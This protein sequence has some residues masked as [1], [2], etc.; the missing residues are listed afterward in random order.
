MNILDLINKFSTQEKCIKHLEKARWGDKVKCVY[1][2]SDNTNSLPKELRHHCNG[3]RK[4]FSVTVGTIFHRTHIELQKWFLV[5][6]L[7][8]NARKGLSAYQIAR[9][10]GMRRP[11]VWSMMHRIRKAMA[12][13]Q[14]ELLSGIVEMDETYI[15]GKPRPKNNKDDDDYTP[16]KRGRGTD[17]ECVIGMIERGGKVKTKHH[18]KKEGNRLDFK[19]LH[20]ILFKNISPESTTLMTDDFKGYKPFKKVI[21]HLSVNHSK[22]QWVSGLAH[23]NTIESFWAIVKRGIKGQFHFVS[24]KYLSMYLDEFCWRFNNKESEFMFDKLLINAVR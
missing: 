9:D 4:S 23:T 2:G 17:K 11:T 20:S 14:G 24:P 6:S 19:S 8:L 18:S 16:P 10:L 13:D 21:S 15:G 7:M 12:S 3:C 5:M 1:C 22:K